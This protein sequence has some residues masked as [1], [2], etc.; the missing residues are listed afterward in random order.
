M[1]TT[2]FPLILTYKP[3]IKEKKKKRRYLLMLSKSFLRTILK[4]VDKKIPIINLSFTNEKE[5]R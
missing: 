3:Q 2:L 1:R 4:E 5:C